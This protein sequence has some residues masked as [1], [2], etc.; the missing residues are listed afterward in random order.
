MDSTVLGNA[1]EI[2][3]S[4]LKLERWLY[5]LLLIKFT[6]L[7]MFRPYSR[8][9]LVIYTITDTTPLNRWINICL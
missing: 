3:Y 6:M 5:Y 7:K 9:S 8:D 4:C 1:K 2:R